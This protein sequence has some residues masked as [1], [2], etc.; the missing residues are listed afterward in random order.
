MLFK[1]TYPDA[2]TVKNLELI[3]NAHNPS[4]SHSL[5]GVL[6]HTKTSMGTRLLRSNILQPPYGE[7]SGLH[8][9][10]TERHLYP[11]FVLFLT[12]DLGTVNMRLDCVA[13]E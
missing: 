13:G 8:S 5:F 11:V 12:I 10:G 2:T 3:S 6:N 1:S 4:S 7:P 9:G